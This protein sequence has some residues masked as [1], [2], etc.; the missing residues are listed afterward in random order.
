MRGIVSLVG[1]TG[2]IFFVISCDNSGFSDMTPSEW[3]L[4]PFVSIGSSSVGFLFGASKKPYECNEIPI[5]VT[6]PIPRISALID[7]QTGINNIESITV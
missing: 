3:L 5:K 4:F 1:S 6:K 2:E 7:I